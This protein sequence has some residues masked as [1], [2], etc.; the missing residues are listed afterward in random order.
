ML[1]DIYLEIWLIYVDILNE[2]VTLFVAT[3]LPK[4][5]IISVTFDNELINCCKSLGV[6]CEK[7]LIFTNTADDILFWM[8]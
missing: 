5:N 3:S 7:F 6:E 8:M 2:W 4:S 1:D